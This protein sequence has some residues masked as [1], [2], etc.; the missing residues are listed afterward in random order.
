[1]EV[2]IRLILQAF[3]SG[4]SSALNVIVNILNLVQSAR[5]GQQYSEARLPVIFKTNDGAAFDS[6]M[7]LLNLASVHAMSACDATVDSSWAMQ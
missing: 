3:E 5:H 4:D 7:E 1:M 2:T 6:L